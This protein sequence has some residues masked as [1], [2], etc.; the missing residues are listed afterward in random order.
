MKTLIGVLGITFL[1]MAPAA[2][3]QDKQPDRLQS[4]LPGSTPRVAGMSVL[5][6][7][8]RSV[9]PVNRRVVYLK[10]N[11]EVLKQPISERNMLFSEEHPQSAF[12]IPFSLLRL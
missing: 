9:V 4:I 12:R 5:A 11:V 3:S 7:S 10:G 6:E 8:I 1:L 2:D